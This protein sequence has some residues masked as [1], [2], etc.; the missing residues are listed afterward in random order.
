MR[1]R[2]V[3]R[4]VVR[5]SSSVTISPSSGRLSVTLFV[6]PPLVTSLEYSVNATRRPLGDHSGCVTSLPAGNS[7]SVSPMSIGHA[8]RR[9]EHLDVPEGRHEHAAAVGVQRGEARRGPR[10]CARAVSGAMLGAAGA[11]VG[12]AARNATCEP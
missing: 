2:V 3:A 4:P 5:S 8:G 7:A 9:V 10:R 6:E 1:R 11:V 12:A